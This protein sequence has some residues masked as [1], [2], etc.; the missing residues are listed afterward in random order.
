MGL[1]SIFAACFNADRTKGKRNS[2]PGLFARRRTA[3]RAAAQKERYMARPVQE[4]RRERDDRGAENSLLQRE[5]DDAIRALDQLLEDHA[6]L[7]QSTQRL[8]D[9]NERLRRAERRRNTDAIERGLLADGVSVTLLLDEDEQPLAGKRNSPDHIR[10]PKT[11][12]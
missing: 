6:R 7:N 12:K 1:L 3:A 2:K 10:A 8:R 11:F 5:V 4:L 9:E